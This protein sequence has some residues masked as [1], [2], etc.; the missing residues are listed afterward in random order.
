M[1]KTFTTLAMLTSIAVPALAQ[2]H[3][4]TTYAA[5]VAPQYVDAAPAGL[6]VGDQ[7]LRY[8][9][10]SFELNGPI[11]GVYYGQATLI[12]LDSATE[13]SARMYLR[14]EIF[15]DGSIYTSD[16]VQVDHG[17]PIKEGH[18]HEGAIIGGTGKYAGIR[19]TYT[20]HLVPTENVYE[21]VYSYWLGQ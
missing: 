15:P 14:E 7:Y 18:K 1:K 21:T 9:D 13:K 2:D 5:H 4:L 19:G 11:V 6:S 12:F 3:S 8:N 16:V 10:I 17:G 20:L